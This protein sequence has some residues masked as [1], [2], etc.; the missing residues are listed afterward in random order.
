MA[1]LTL[2]L[3]TPTPGAVEKSESG[4]TGAAHKAAD[5][6]RGA[7]SVAV[8]LAL[9]ASPLILLVV[10]AWLVLRVRNR[11]IETRLLDDPRPGTS[12]PPT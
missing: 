8:F 4:I 10:V 7:G 5:F 3:A 6:L 2:R 9:V 1:D 11:R 12:T